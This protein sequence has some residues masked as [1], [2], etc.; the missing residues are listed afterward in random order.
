M[1]NIS[2]AANVFGIGCAELLNVFLDPLFIFGIG[3]GIAEAGLAV[4]MTNYILLGYCLLMFH[5]RR[6]TTVACFDPPPL[7]GQGSYLHGDPSRGDSSR[8]GTDVYEY[9]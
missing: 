6:K 3:M 5:C 7:S 4:C 8:S 9:L 2:C 1:M